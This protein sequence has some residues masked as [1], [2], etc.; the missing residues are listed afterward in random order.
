MN[1][2]KVAVQIGPS[3]VPLSTWHARMLRVRKSSLE[4]APPERCA[5]VLGHRY[6]VVV[7]P[8]FDYEHI[9]FDG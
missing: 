7:K 5:L 3:R 2:W 8:V 4:A 9:H 6:V 1:P